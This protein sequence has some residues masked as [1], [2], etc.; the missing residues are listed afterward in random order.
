MARVDTWGGYAGSLPLSDSTRSRHNDTD[1]RR[2]SQGCSSLIGSLDDLVRQD[3]ER[4]ENREAERFRRLEVDDE[5][6]LHGL[7]HRQIGR[8]GALEPSAV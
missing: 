7:H 2:A 5:L 6:K 3:Q 1:D 8:F 4:R